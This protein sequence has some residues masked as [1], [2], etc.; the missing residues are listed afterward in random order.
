MCS[1]LTSVSFGQTAAT[2]YAA[3]TY[4]QL[5]A[6]APCRGSGRAA[7][8]FDNDGEF[9]L[10]EAALHL[11]KW[12]KPEVADNRIW[13]YDG[14][15][16]ILPLPSRAYPNLPASLSTAEALQ[17]LQSPDIATL[18]GELCSSCIHPFWQ[19]F[20]NLACGSWHQL[21]SQGQASTTD[22]QLATTMCLA[23]AGM[24]LSPGGM[25]CMVE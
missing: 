13:L 9:L 16:H 12:L 19:Q 4:M 24:L 5:I 25:T 7:R 3:V 14:A 6:P 10:I 21:L 20:I 18:A 1:L 23:L 2:H 15:V 17:M 11:P 22:G 8:I